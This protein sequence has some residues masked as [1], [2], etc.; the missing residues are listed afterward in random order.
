MNVS[1]VI[2]AEYE[3]VTPD[4]PASK[5]MGRFTDTSTRG[6][7]VVGDEFEGVVTRRQ[8]STSH[9]N[10]EEKAGS[11]VRPVPRLAPDEDIR[12]VAH[13]MLESDSQVLPVFEDGTLVGAVTAG[14]ILRAVQSHLEVATVEDAM[15]EQLLLVTPDETLGRTLALLREHRITHLPVVGDDQP[16]GMVSLADL[17]DLTVRAMHRSQGGDGGGTDPFGGEISSSAARSRRGGY[18]AREGERERMLDLPIRDVMTQPVRTV[19]PGATLD[20][21]AGEL[22]DGE[23]SSLVVADGDELAGILT[24]TDVLDVLTWEAERRRAVQVYGIDL[25]EGVTHETVVGMVDR[26]DERDGG[27]SVLDA[28]VH[29]QAH[30]ERR[31]G[32]PLVLARVRLHTDRGLFIASGE[33]YGATQALNEARD[34]LERRIQDRKTHGQSKKPP[35]EEFWERRFG[36]F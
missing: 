19:S 8:L 13:L 18:G 4:T 24:T 7:L 22:L 16:V 30:D 3:T 6:V 17:T 26:F 2:T 15:T 10:P 20:T 28:K 35:G 23:G 33:G 11:L 1:D 34:I 5:L 12:R 21:A 25:L 32:V 36:W 14:S 31:R 9:H 29:L 27:M